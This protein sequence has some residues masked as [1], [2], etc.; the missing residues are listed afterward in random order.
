MHFN[1]VLG[2]AYTLGFPP[3]TYPGMAEPSMVGIPG[4]ASVYFL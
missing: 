1:D 3:G 2:K 4:Y